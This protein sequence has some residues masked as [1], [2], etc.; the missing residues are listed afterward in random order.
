MYIWDNFDLH[1]WKMDYKQKQKNI[2]LAVFSYL[3]FFCREGSASGIDGYQS[4]QT[5]SYQDLNDP[6][7]QSQ[8]DAFFNRVQNENATRREYV[9][10]IYHNFFLQIVSSDLPP[11]QGGKYGGFGYS[12][13]PPPRSSS[14][15]FVG[16]A[17]SSF[18]S[19]SLL[20]PR[21]SRSWIFVRRQLAS[22]SCE[23]IFC[24]FLN[25]SRSF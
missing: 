25:F 24:H 14:Q 11:N 3:T 13:D 6:G 19:V 22:H 1:M 5:N 20:T 12:V 16:T 17:L 9:R 10:N 7:F 21:E 18:A 15:E 2:M 23:R 8:R 4:P